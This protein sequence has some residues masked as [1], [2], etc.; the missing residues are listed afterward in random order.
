MTETLTTPSSLAG[1]IFGQWQSDYAER[2]LPTFPVEIDGT[3]KVPMT[4][5]YQRVGIPGS[6]ELAKRYGHAGAMGLTLNSSLMVVDVDTK[7]ENALA[8]VLARYGNTP[9][10]ARTASKGGYHAYYG[11][12]SG[13]W[14]YHKGR[15]IIRPEPEKPVDYLGAGFA[16]VPPSLAPKGRYEFICGSLDDLN[17]LPPLKGQVPPLQPETKEDPANEDIPRISIGARDN[18]LWRDCMKRA[19]LCENFDQLLE[20]ARVINSYYLPP[21][22]ASQVTKIA[23]SAWGYTETGRNRFG[24]HGIYLTKNEFTSMIHEQDALLLL[25]FL[26]LENGPTSQFMVANGLTDTLRWSLRRLQSARQKLLELKEIEQIRKPSEGKSALFQWG[27]K[28][29]G[30]RGE[31]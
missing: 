28:R 18:K 8:D 29:R 23:K 30:K 14:R 6:T 3:N 22:D 2:G 1:N 9:L 15:R 10:I 11:N 31:M 26:R 27:D 12:N 16:V 7:S 17:H 13:A 5:G 21:M 25:Q 24:Q 4:R 20:F 19:K